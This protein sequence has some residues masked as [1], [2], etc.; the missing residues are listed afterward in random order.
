MA[1]LLKLLVLYVD[2]IL[3]KPAPKFLRQSENQHMIN[4][5]IFTFMGLNS[6]IPSVFSGALG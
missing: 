2:K 1:L 4:V 3:G 5:I 6:A